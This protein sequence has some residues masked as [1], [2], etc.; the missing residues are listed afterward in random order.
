MRQPGRAESTLGGT[1]QRP[2]SKRARRIELTAQFFQRWHIGVPLDH[3]GDSPEATKGCAVEFP[4]RIRHRM[5]VSVDEVVAVILVPRQ[6]KL[7]H[8]LDGNRIEVVQ[9]R[10]LMVHT[11]DIDVID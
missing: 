11:A 7:L 1:R 4:Y 6:M 8:P 10:E 3:R 2:L 9:R 5:I